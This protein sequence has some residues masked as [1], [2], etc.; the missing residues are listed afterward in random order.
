MVRRNSATGEVKTSLNPQGFIEQRY[1]GKQTTSNIEAGVKELSE[2]IT[3]LRAEKTPILILIDVSEV[4]ID[5]DRRIHKAGIKG[6]NAISFKRGAV[7]GSL[8]SQVLIN[9]LALV[10][11]KQHKVQAF[12]SRDEAIK[13][14]MEDAK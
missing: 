13:W 7:Y 14:L 9:T 5:F 1:W 4:I 8:S 6:M 12:V 11:G 2:Y 3:A 10:A